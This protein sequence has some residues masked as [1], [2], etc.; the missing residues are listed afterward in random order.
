MCSFSSIAKRQEICT[1]MY[2]CRRICLMNTK[3]PDLTLN[4]N[5][6]DVY[7]YTEI[8][9]SIQLLDAIWVKG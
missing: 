4:R 3:G 7:L 8:T 5:H 1:A 6:Q 9:F 2:K